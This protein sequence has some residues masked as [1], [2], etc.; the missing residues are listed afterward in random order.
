MSLQPR[1]GTA[2]QTVVPSLVAAERA[3]LPTPEAVV[4]DEDLDFRDARAVIRRT[5]G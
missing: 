3:Y 4:T 1:E 2:M 5:S